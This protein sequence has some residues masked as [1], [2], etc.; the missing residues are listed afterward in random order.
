MNELQSRDVRCPYCGEVYE[1]VI[2]CSVPHQQYIE[3]CEICCR[4]ILFTVTVAHDHA[5]TV[6]VA[7]EDE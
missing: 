4:P 3:D 1:V 7:G 6:T 5:V 2:D